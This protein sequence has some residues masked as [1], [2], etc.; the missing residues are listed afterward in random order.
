MK[1]IAV[2]GV[3]V[4]F[5]LGGRALCAAAQALPCLCSVAGTQLWCRDA[6]MEPARLWRG[7]LPTCKMGAREKK[8]RE[9]LER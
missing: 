5:C 2:G 3:M 7:V 9:E 8:K 4:G 1:P 6:K